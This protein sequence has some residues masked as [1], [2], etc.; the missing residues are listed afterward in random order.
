MSL[1]LSH[2]IAGAMASVLAGLAIFAG[3]PVQ[4]AAL[5]PAEKLYAD[6]AKLDPAERQDRILEGAKK[7]SQLHFTNSLGGT[8]GRNYI[9][10]FETA[11]PFLKSDPLYISDPIA[12]DQMLAESTAGR[13]Y[14][15]AL[16]GINITEL[17]EV[18][19]RNLV[20]RYPTPAMD[21][22]LPRYRIFKDPE[23]RWTPILWSEKGVS[24]NPTMLKPEE[25]P[26]SFSDLCNPLL[27]GQVSFEPIRA[28]TVYHVWLAFDSDMRKTEEW[29]KCMG[30]NKP[31]LYKGHTVRLQL[32]YAG[33][34]AVQGDNFLYQG[35]LDNLKNPKK[36][37]FKAVYTVPVLASASTG[38]INQA[39][40]HPYASALLLD[41]ALTDEP[42]EYLKKAFRGPVT[43]SHPYMPDDVQ[44]IKQPVP[45]EKILGELYTLWRKYMGVQ[46]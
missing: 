10:I 35:T 34:H 46:G 38:I 3:P 31:I 44:M 43:L 2:V 5:S 24:Y 16:T 27:N 33:D 14:K 18:L 29:M 28:Y 9:K 26:K 32:M 36:A 45:D 20:A 42:Q 8:L 22:I 15:E 11:Y 1:N 6:L 30:S 23:N 39:T 25:A 37:P 12:I 17:T 40:P 21:K 19:N 4:G 41:W 13:V 7:E